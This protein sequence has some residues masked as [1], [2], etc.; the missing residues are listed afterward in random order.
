[1]VVRGSWL[2]P[3]KLFLS[4]TKKDFEEAM[5]EGD[6]EMADVDVPTLAVF[7]TMVAV[8]GKVVKLSR[9]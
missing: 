6:P 2:V 1:M 8:K 3:S 9:T 4:V 5:L 7:T